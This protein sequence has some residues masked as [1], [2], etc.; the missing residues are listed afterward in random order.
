MWEKILTDDTL[1]NMVDMM[2]EDVEEATE[3]F[4]GLVAFVEHVM[5]WVDYKEVVVLATQWSNLLDIRQ[6]NIAVN[7]VGEEHASRFIV[8]MDYLSEKFKNGELK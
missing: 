4:Q 6:A 3:D 1:Q 7:S 5:A 2:T 8:M